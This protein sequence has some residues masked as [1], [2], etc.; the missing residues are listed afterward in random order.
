MATLLPAFSVRY[1]MENWNLQP[2]HDS[3]RQRER[4][5]GVFLNA[6]VIQ[7]SSQLNPERDKIF[8]FSGQQPENLNFGRW[9][10]AQQFRFGEQ[11]DF[12]LDLNS[13]QS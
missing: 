2:I 5:P 6:K 3:N 13:S 11:T 10:L 4:V 8:S 9:N 7:A 12:T 1:E